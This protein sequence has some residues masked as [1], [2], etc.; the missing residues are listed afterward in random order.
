MNI[1]QVATRQK[2]NWG[3]AVLCL[4]AVVAWSAAE[5]EL[6]DG[7]PYKED[8]VRWNG[9]FPPEKNSGPGYPGPL[10]VQHDSPMST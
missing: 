7:S 8:Y 10:P 6:P 1:E 9:A 3:V 2:K 4:V 5:V